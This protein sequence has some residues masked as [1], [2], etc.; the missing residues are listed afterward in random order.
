MATMTLEAAYRPTDNEPF[1]NER[2]REY[3]RAQAQRLEGRHPAREPGDPGG[4]PEREREPP[5]SRRPRILGDRPRDR[6]ARPRPAA[7]ADRQDR[8]R[9]GAD[10]RRHLRLL[11]GDR[12]ADLAQAPRGPADRDAVDRGAGAP[13][14]QRARLSRRLSREPDRAI[15]SRGVSQAPPLPSWRRAVRRFEEPEA[16]GPGR[17]RLPAG[18]KAR[19]R[20]TAAG[21]RA[22]DPG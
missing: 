15:A 13:R 4:T 6:A 16:R 9:A 14:A 8:R 17:E 7:Q 18:G 3:F 1:M 12:R 2:Q 11:R 19:R 5:R 20:A 21:E 10:R 22:D